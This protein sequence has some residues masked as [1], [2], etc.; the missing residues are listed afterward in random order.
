MTSIQTPVRPRGRTR[1]YDR[2]ADAFPLRPGEKR[3]TAAGVY[4]KVGI[5]VVL[6]IATG[7]VGYFTNPSGALIFVG[8][9]AGLG[10]ALTGRFKPTTAVVVAPLYALVEGYVLGAITSFYAAGQSSIVPAAVIFTGGIFLGALIIFRSG[11]VKVTH[12]FVVM[13]GM[14]FVGFFLVVLA[15]LVGIV[16]LTSATANLWIGIFGVVLGVMFLFLDF[17]FI[18]VTEQR[19]LSAKGE[20]LGALLLMNALVMVYINVLG[21]LGRRR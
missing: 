21:I 10:L 7:F 11:L 17:N 20:W 16:S 3:F 19:Q 12:R 1:S 8:I 4:D 15:Q 5:L 14:A 9:F 18:Q 13:A 2:L 6:A